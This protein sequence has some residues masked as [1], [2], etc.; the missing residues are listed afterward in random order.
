LRQQRRQQSELGV[1]MRGPVG[2]AFRAPIRAG[3]PGSITGLFCGLNI[4]LTISPED[5]GARWM[6]LII[7]FLSVFCYL[8][9][10]VKARDL[11]Q[12]ENVDPAIRQ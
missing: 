7:L 4:A 9:T 12:W 10:D 5:T 1:L 3:W 2:G 6:K 11:G 8:V